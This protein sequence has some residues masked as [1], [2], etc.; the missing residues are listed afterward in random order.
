MGKLV[1]S[2]YLLI[3]KMH[4]SSRQVMEVPIFQWELGE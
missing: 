2:K 3:E 1:A 4:V